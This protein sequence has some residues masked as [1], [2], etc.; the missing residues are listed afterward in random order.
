MTVR[1]CIYNP[2]KYQR[3]LGYKA[4][5][6]RCRESVHHGRQGLGQCPRKPTVWETVDGQRM[7]FCKQ[8][9]LA[10]QEER[11]AKAERRYEKKLR[12]M[13]PNFDRRRLESTCFGAISRMHE[14]DAK[15]AGI[16]DLWQQ[17]Q[18]QIAKERT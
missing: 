14:D 17:V 4:D 2:P 8:H 18:D 12:D 3:E 13:K 7:G 6:E 9:S 5:E 10:A 1:H 15:A 11:A 16:Q